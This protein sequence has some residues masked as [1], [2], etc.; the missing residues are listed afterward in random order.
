MSFFI[1]VLFFCLQGECYF[2]KLQDNFDKIEQ[3]Q[4]AVKQF[5]DYATKERIKPAMVCLK[6]DL[7]A[8]I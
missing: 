6:V 8:N 7:K 3:C 1:G 4:E 2:V 5:H